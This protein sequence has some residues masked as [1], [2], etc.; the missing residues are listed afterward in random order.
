M[1][2]VTFK[3]DAESHIGR[4]CVLAGPHFRP[5]IVAIIVACEKSAP[6]ELDEIKFTEGW[7]PGRK[8]RDLHTEW[9]AL[10]L[11]LNYAEWVEL[12]YEER[13]G[14][15]QDWALRITQI[16]GDDYQAIAHGSGRSLHI[17]IELD[18]KG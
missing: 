7:R 4:G 5:E 16:L 15:G 12:T 17:H 3:T 6:E 10:D 2:R 1:P 9:R 13:K 11:G 18:P 14:R 8:T